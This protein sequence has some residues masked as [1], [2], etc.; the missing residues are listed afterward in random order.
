[1]VEQV[2]PGAVVD[3]GVVSC[4]TASNVVH[5]TAGRAYVKA[6]LAFA[7]GS[8]QNLGPWNVLVTSSLKRTGPGHYVTATC[9]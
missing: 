7:R 8:D 6:G 1:M 4:T 5:V 2:A 3:D 9:P